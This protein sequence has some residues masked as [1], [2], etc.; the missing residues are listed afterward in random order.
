MPDGKEVELKYVLESSDDASKLREELGSPE[1]RIRQYNFFFDTPGRTLLAVR[2][3]LRLRI[4]RPQVAE[5]RAILTCKFSERVEGS[6]AVREEIESR[7]D[8]DEVMDASTSG[9]FSLVLGHDAAKPILEAA[10][11]ALGEGGLGSQGLVVVGGFSTM[12]EVYAA[13][14]HTGG[15]LCLDTVAYPVGE[16]HVEVEMEIAAESEAQACREAVEDL[17]TRVG[18]KFSPGT[19]SKYARL[20]RLMAPGGD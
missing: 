2:A 11:K 3:A 19:E 20:R 1:D 16:E 14:G 8:L 4:E 18:V 17:L 12:R 10:G 15:E 13:P 9:S 5:P 6:L 7:L